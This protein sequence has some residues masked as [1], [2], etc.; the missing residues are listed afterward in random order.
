[1]NTP[2]NAATFLD[3]S[4]M[5]ARAVQRLGHADET[6]PM[7]AFHRPLSTDPRIAQLR[8]AGA[9]FERRGQT[10]N[11]DTCNDLASKL[12]RFG[13]F[14][15]EKQSGFAAQLI[16]WAGVD[17][18]EA[19]QAAPGAPIATSV[20]PAP[21]PAPAVRLERLHAVMQGM[22]KLRLG[23]VTIARKNQ[24]QLCWVKWAGHEQV[25]GKIDNGALTVFAGRLR[26]VTVAEVEARLRVID[27]DPK[28]A[29]A[30][31][32]QES[33]NCSVCGRDLT[34]PSSIALGI[35]PVCIAGF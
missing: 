28:A 2:F 34:D 33:G 3:V 7:R 15:S 24:D 13:S 26:G 27:L 6:T 16:R 32:G 19:A 29:A 31:H 1:M 21:A 18:Q 23:D 5:S 11:A 10:R 4:N 14:V 8:L 12:E 30:A 35:G 9:H 20:V 17:A 25:V 22:A